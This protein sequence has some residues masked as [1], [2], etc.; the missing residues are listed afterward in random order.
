[1]FVLLVCKS[2]TLGDFTNISDVDILFVGTVDSGTPSEPLFF[3]K[4]HFKR[5]LFLKF[6]FQNN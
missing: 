6:K 3:E 5:D 2:N 4:F 1:M